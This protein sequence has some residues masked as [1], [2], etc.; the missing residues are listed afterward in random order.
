MRPF[1]RQAHTGRDHDRVD[2]CFDENL[3]AH[4][5]IDLIRDQHMSLVLRLLSCVIV[6]VY[7]THRPR[8]RARPATCP[9]SL[10]LPAT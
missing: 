6:Q 5:L 9:P 8:K 4:T 3:I 10:A 7:L 1:L 2:D